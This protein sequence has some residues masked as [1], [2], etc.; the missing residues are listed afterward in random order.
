M[1]PA[2]FVEPEIAVTAAI[3]AAICSPGARKAMRK[4]L[5]YGIAGVLTAGDVVTSFA[6][7]MRQGV[8]QTG[9][10]KAAA[11]AVKEEAAQPSKKAEIKAV[12]PEAAEPQRKTT[13]KK[14]TGGKSA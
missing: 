8:E 5:V 2:D 3:T 11:T 9:N 14:S 7:S 4:G 12:E 6:R 13:K 1:E 10:G